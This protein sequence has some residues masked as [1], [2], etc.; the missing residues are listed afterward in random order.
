[1]AVADAQLDQDQPQAI[2]DNIHRRAP[3]RVRPLTPSFGLEVMGVSDI[4][5]TPEWL[6][7]TL[8]QLW[9]DEGVLVFRGMAFDEAGQVAFS[10]IFGN[11]E[12]HGQVAL[13]SKTHPELMYLTN[14]KDLGIPDYGTKSSELDWHSDQVYLPRPALGSLLYAVEV[15]EGHGDTYW[16][17]LRTAYDRLPKA[18]KARI[19]GMVAVFDYAITMKASNAQPSAEQKKRSALIE[20]HPLVR[21]HPITLRKSLYLSPQTVSHIEGLSATESR[22]LLDELHEAV[23]MPDLIYRHSWKVGDAIV[24]DNARVIHRRDTF[25]DDIPRFMKRTTISAPAGLSIPF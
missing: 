1:M 18:T 14:R 10:R 2:H 5:G 22:K 4:A 11:C 25:P 8:L 13:N 9:G 17:D 15:P 6:R 21:T 3:L 12:I 20:R 23:L 24:W 7:R 19:D 16:A